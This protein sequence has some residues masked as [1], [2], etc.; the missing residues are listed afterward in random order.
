VSAARVELRGIVQSYPDPKGSGET[1]VVD[2][3]DLDLQGPGIHMLLGPSGCGK[4]TVLR[5]MGGVRPL[6][7]KTPSQGTVLIDGQPC[8][9]PH[10]D[11]VMVF[12]RYLNRPDLRVRDNVAFPFRGRLWRKRV[13]DEAERGRRVTDALRDV[14]L[15]DKADH[16]PPQL[17]GGQNQRVALAR[18]LVLRPR[19]LLMDEPFGALDAQIRLEMQQ[20]LGQLQAEHGF[21]AVFVTHDVQEALLLGDRVT[22]LSTRPARVAL[23]FVISEPRPRSPLWL[24]TTEASQRHDEILGVLKGAVR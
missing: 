12:Q 13:P 14:G 10:D 21:L 15:H 20:L 17:S 3:I 6:G 19:I 8:V 1:R 4:S 7:V 23:D 2:G 24:R 11:A 16:R 18:A 9:A 5:M 22:V